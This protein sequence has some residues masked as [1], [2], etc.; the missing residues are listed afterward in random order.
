MTL[1][2][3]QPNERREA[4][5]DNALE[6]PREYFEVQ[7]AFALQWARLSGENVKDT[8]KQKTALVRRISTDS[9]EQGMAAVN[10][11]TLL[12]RLTDT[13]YTLY[14]DNPDS[15]VKNP[16]NTPREIFGTEY[17]S[18]TQTIK[19]HFLGQP[20]SS[21]NVL[22]EGNLENRRNSATR[23]VTEEYKKHPEASIV[24]GGSWLYNLQSY[25]D[26]FP[27]RFTQQLK[28]LVP[29]GLATTADVIG[30]MSFQGN[31]L[32][33]QF[34]N[35]YRQVREDRYEEFMEAIIGAESTDELI[36]AFPLK[37]LHA[38]CS[39]QDFLSI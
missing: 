6:F 39:P 27:P 33:G 25:R 28:R 38:S 31:S 13:L 12:S 4:K 5:R 24:V 23:A 26:S 9:W 15:I 11:E 10:D 20:R 17:Y 30:G 2:N 36:D 29:E 37:P 19:I 22:A 21:Q 16:E 7:V 32:W 3:R 35:H 18:D 1:E 8:L 14:A 34:V